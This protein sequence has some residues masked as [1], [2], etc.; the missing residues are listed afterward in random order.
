MICPF[1]NKLVQQQ[2]LCLFVVIPEGNLRFALA[3]T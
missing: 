3:T 2:L 1:E